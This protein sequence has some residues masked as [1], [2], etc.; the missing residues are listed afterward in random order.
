MN[1]EKPNFSSC[2]EDVFVAATNLSDPTQTDLQEINIEILN[3]TH[4]STSRGSI[5]PR[6]AAKGSVQ[7]PADRDTPT[8]QPGLALGSLPIDLKKIGSVRDSGFLDDEDALS[9]RGS[10][11][12]TSR[13]TPSKHLNGANKAYETVSED[14]PTPSDLISRKMKSKTRAHQCFC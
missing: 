6:N 12:T 3:E 5:M 9:S 14:A 10:E 13:K 1:Q 4:N 11:L 7:S 8:T 2:S